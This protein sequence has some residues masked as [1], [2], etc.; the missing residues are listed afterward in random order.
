MK[1]GIL[2]KGFIL[3]K[4]PLCFR[5]GG[6]YHLKILKRFHRHIGD[7]PLLFAGKLAR[8]AE[9]QIIL[10]EL[11]AIFCRLK[12]SQS[13]DGFGSRR[14]GKDEAVGLIRTSKHATAKLVEL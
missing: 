11:K 2:C 3:F 8:A 5:A 13:F 10:G 14:V 9:L 4:K 1:E 12:R 6:L 7:A